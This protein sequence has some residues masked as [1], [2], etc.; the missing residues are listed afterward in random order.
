[1]VV[2]IHP[3]QL[4]QVESGCCLFRSDSVF[5]DRKTSVFYTP[6][7]MEMCWLSEVDVRVKISQMQTELLRILRQLIPIHHDSYRN[8]RNRCLNVS[9]LNQFEQVVQS[10]TVLFKTII[11]E[12]S[13]PQRGDDSPQRVII[14][15]EILSEVVP[16][17]EVPPFSLPQFGGVVEAGRGALGFV[18][19]GVSCVSSQENLGS[20]NI[21]E[22]SAGPSNVDAGGVVWGT[23]PF[24]FHPVESDET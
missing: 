7:C 8:L 11:R 23:N 24:D 10:I 3:F 20:S 16:Q 9:E 15:S 22:I 2:K 18:V 21:M 6:S 13:P 12:V 4:L 5:Y 17:V 14:Q 19:S 1:M